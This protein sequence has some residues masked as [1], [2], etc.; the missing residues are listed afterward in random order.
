MKKAFVLILT[1]A[2][3]YFVGLMYPA[4]WLDAADTS[5][6][7]LSKHAKSTAQDAVDLAASKLKKAD[8]AIK[9][10]IAEREAQDCTKPNCKVPVVDLSK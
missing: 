2:I 7:F 8:R 4:F 10:K 1:F 6:K 3:G 9:E 5:G